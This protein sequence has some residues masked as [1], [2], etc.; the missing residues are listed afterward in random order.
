MPM[1]NPSKGGAK[2]VPTFVDDYSRYFVAYLLLKKS[3]VAIKLRELMTFYEKQL[4]KR[5][6]CLPSD[7][8]TELVNQE[9]TKI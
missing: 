6:K 7:N 4:V 8:E 2:Y 9:M 5:L 3:E 1:K